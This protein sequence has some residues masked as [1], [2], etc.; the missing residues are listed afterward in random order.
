MKK[1]NLNY[2]TIIYLLTH[3]LTYS[4]TQ[5]LY[6]GV[7]T[8]G[9]QFLK[10]GPSARALG[11]AGAFGAVADDLYALHFNPSGLAQ[12]S[13]EEASA[14]YLRYFADIN[15]GFIG[16]ARPTKIGAVGFGFTYLIIDDIEKRDVDETLLGKFNA[17]DQ[18]IT[19][20]YA[21]KNPFPQLLDGLDLGGNIRYIQSEIDQTL[22]YTASLDLSAMYSP[23]EKIKTSLAVQNISWGIKFKE[24]TDQLPLNLKVAGAWSPIDELTIAC[25]L[26]EYLIDSK[27]YASLGAEYWPIKQLAIRAGYKYGY[28]TESL[29][30]LVGLGAGLGFRLWNLGLDYAFVPFGELGDTHRITFLI[31]F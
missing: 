16:Y 3:L 9:A 11:M 8:T 25:D 28:D 2:L 15:Y 21:K 31:K 6:A 17:K 10:I 23:A 24:E 14:T 30:S 20:A 1:I 19:F 22:A 12:M 18:A 27:F 29:G 7:G 13:Q 4:L 5:P 26:D